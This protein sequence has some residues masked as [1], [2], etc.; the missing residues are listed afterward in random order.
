MKTS[1]LERLKE[2]FSRSALGGDFLTVRAAKNDT[3]LFGP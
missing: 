1:I 2:S 3:P